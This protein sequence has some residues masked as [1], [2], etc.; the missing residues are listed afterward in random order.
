[1]EIKRLEPKI[2]TYKLIPDKNDE[3]YSSCAWARFVFD[4]NNGSLTIDSDAGDYF[5]RWGY[6]EN[7]DFMHLM[8]RIDKWYLINKL[9]NRSIFLLEESK[10]EN[11]KY[12][13]DNGWEYFGI[14]S[15]EKWKD[16]KQNILDINTY[17]EETF[18]RTINDIIPDIDWESIIVEKDYPRSAKVIVRLFEKYLQ[19]KI[20]EDF[21][22]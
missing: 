6:N 19:P 16:C 12:I 20:R 17:S 3:E 10:K 18:L 14:D 8:G 21:M 1:M 2:Y 4:C 9:S 15:E 5:Y 22:K 13:E 7:E 11:I